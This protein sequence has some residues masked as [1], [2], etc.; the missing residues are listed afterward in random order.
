MLI[1]W[2]KDSDR[3]FSKIGNQNLLGKVEIP[4][5]IGVYTLLFHPT[6]IKI[7]E[8]GVLYSIYWVKVNCSQ[9]KR[10]DN[11]W[12]PNDT[13]I[14]DGLTIPVQLLYGWCPVFWL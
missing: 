5:F 9:K 2:K 14:V 7:I 10:C 11:H 12:V 4:G 1:I 8:K 6:L 3:D 13:G